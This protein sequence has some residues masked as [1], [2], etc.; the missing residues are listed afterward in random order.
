MNSLSTEII[1]NN[2]ETSISNFSSFNLTSNFLTTSF[3][4]LFTGTTYLVAGAYF[5]YCYLIYTFV[6]FPLGGDYLPDCFKLLGELG[7]AYSGGRISFFAMSSFFITTL[8]HLIS[9]FL[10]KS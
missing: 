7:C 2:F 10:I 1:L 6:A 5:T 9:N 8:K 3:Y 4:S